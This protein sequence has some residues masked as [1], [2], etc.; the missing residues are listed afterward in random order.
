MYLLVLKVR[1]EE[2]FFITK[3]K[4]SEAAPVVQKAFINGVSTRQIEKLTNSLG[5][6]RIS[7]S[8]VSEITKGLSEQVS[9]FR[10]VKITTG[11]PIY[12]VGALYEKVR[13]NGK[14]K[15]M[16]VIVVCGGDKQEKSCAGY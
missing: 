10:N 3:R 14:V 5:S 7:K 1:Q 2:G 8:Q 9:E 16:A 15:S 6:S 13:K 11:Y 4:R 12:G